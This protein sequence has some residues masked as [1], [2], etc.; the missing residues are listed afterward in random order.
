MQ[1]TAK[2]TFTY[3]VSPMMI[4]TMKPNKVQNTVS[5]YLDVGFRSFEIGPL[6]FWKTVFFCFFNLQPTSYG[7]HT[8]YAYCIA[9][10]IHHLLLIKF[11]FMKSMISTGHK[12][13]PGKPQ[14]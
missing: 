9:V 12:L 3:R 2:L 14:P 13:H 5:Y 7:I 4:T 10:Y 8:P 6:N 1:H 11:R